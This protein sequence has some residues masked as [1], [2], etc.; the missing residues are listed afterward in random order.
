MYN[1][2]TG[3]SQLVFKDG[4]CRDNDNVSAVHFSPPSA[5]GACL[6]SKYRIVGGKD[7][8][9]QPRFV[10]G[11]KEGNCSD[12][13]NRSPTTVYVITMVKI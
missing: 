1:G 10:W 2:R 9:F 3:F 5:I 13:F 8:S 6:C 12:E 11:R 7:T 4:L